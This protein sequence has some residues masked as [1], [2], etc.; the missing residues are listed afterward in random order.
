MIE[1]NTKAIVKNSDEN[2]RFR[3]TETVKALTKAV[4]ALGIPPV[5]TKYF[6]QR[7]CSF[8]E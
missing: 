1:E 8:N 5:E 3:P 2:P 7:R 6:I 4:C